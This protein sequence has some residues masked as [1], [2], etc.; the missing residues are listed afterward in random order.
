M[1]GKDNI[2]VEYGK[3]DALSYYDVNDRGLVVNERSKTMKQVFTDFIIPEVN[4]AGIDLSEY[5]YF[6][7]S[8]HRERSH[9]PLNAYRIACFAVTG[10]SEGHYIHV[11]SLSQS[12]N[13]C[14]I[15]GKTFL[16]YDHAL[17]LANALAKILS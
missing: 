11:E 6:S 9:W 3:E 14:L 16:G 1:Q 7:V 2:I 13:E 15:L 5:D 12:G 4:K 10:G 17:K 8:N